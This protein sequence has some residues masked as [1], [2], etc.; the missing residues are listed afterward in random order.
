MNIL[1]IILLVIILLSF[2]FGFKNG[3]IK[4]LGRIIGLVLGIFIALNFAGYVIEWIGLEGKYQ[5]EIGFAIT[6]I[7]VILIVLLLSHI[8][9][10]LIDVV[11]LS[12]INRVL[13]AIFS[14]LT[15]SLILSIIV[16]ILFSFNDKANIVSNEFFTD[17]F[18]YVFLNAVAE[19]IFPFIGEY[20]S[21]SKDFMNEIISQ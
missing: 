20:I 6:L 21:K 18:M 19:T 10:K 11:A 8:L 7:G 9:T 17:S 14:A 15:M 5:Y 4:E 2:V 13:G 12:P 1:D 3:L 16:E